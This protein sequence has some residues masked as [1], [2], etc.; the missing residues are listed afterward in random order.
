MAITE[1][2]SLVRLKDENGNEFIAYPISKGENITYDSTSSKLEAEDVQS[3]IDELA[4]VVHNLEASSGGGGI[5][6]SDTEPTGDSSM[7]W[8]DTGNGGIPKYWNGSA[9]TAVKAVWG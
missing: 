1:V 9:W 2:N 4:G 5:I 6:V 3:A 8:I 7:L